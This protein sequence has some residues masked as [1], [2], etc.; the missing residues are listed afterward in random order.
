MKSHS[1]E[2]KTYSWQKQ[3]LTATIMRDDS[4]NHDWKWLAE[5]QQTEAKAEEILKA[6]LNVTPEEP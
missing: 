5:G 6:V 2:E 1:T 4:P 3:E